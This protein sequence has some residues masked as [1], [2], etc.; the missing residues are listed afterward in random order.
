MGCEWG[1]DGTGMGQGW[2]GDRDGDRDRERER[3]RITAR[4]RTPRLCVLVLLPAV[5]QVQTASSL[6]HS[7][8]PHLPAFSCGAARVCARGNT[9]QDICQR[10]ER[11]ASDRPHK[12]AMRDAMLKADRTR[13]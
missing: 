6:A 3:E 9:A 2:D 12:R 11:G 4:Y 13:A 5:R 10:M 8:I 7:W 1:G